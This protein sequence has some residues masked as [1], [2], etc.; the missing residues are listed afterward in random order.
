MDDDSALYDD[1]E[2]GD[3][4]HSALP[5]LDKPD[6]TD[7]NGSSSTSASDHR[8]SH[9]NTD[10]TDDNHTESGRTRTQPT[11]AA[12][13][14]ADSSTGSA[15][16]VPLNNPEGIDD[17][18]L[19]FVRFRALYSATPADI[20]A[21]LEPQKPTTLYSYLS[22]QGR[23]TGDH[24]ASFT[25]I[26][27]REAVLSREIVAPFTTGGGKIDVHTSSKREQLAAEKRS[28]RTDKRTREDS[29]LLKL[30]GIPFVIRED[31]IEQWLRDNDVKVVDVHIPED[32]QSGR[33]AGNA[34]IEVEDDESA[35]AA[36]KL[37]KST[38][39]NR[40]VDVTRITA[41]EF[42]DELHPTPQAHQYGTPSGQLRRPPSSQSRS[43]GSES[44]SYGGEAAYDYGA[45]P[46]SS[47]PLV[48]QLPRLAPLS[49]DCLFMQ[50]LPIGCQQSDVVDFFGELSIVPLR[51][52]R[53][54]RGPDAFIEF[55]SVDEAE[56]A[57]Q[58]KR[59]HMG[60]RWIDLIR[61]TYTDMC[62]ITG[63][64]PTRDNVPAPAGGRYRDD[65]ETRRRGSRER[66]D[67]GRAGNSDRRD[68]DR[69]YDKRDDRQYGSGGGGGSAAGGDRYRDRSRSPVAR[70]R[71]DD[72]A[73]RGGNGDRDGG[74]GD[75][76]R[77]STRDA[78]GG[79]SSYRDS[80][81]GY[82]GT[83]RDRDERT[84]YRRR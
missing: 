71:G 31:G 18:G 55:R 19:Y 32:A 35:A 57:M 42:E 53:K 10:D 50:G 77:D 5:S 20:L 46:P 83:D 9:L 43:Y 75:Y 33:V 76:G 1:L 44:R 79:G 15:S 22:S 12:S 25:V 13:S 70:R 41:R 6:T 23:R 54:E 39:Q 49:T 69:E 66:D 72:Y 24:F 2:H 51:I 62:R 60:N 61:V 26:E 65:R 3:N 81:R 30:K 36:E 56:R 64:P 63:L 48:H 11:A 17:S 29:V 45:V 7:T 59:R 8:P 21:L 47:G 38:L 27:D 80:D 4:N 28:K 82:D 34:L 14:A 58:L 67:G 40:Y 84:D 37:S 73:S 68:R 78:R 74:R 52:H 16:S